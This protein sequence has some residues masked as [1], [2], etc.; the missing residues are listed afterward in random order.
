M[1][2]S[3]SILSVLS[4][5]IDGTTELS[6]DD[7]TL[8]PGGLTRT[9]V[10]GNGKVLGAR[11]E[12]MESTLEF[13]VAIT[14]AFS[15][16]DFRNMTSSQVQCQADTGQI[17]TINGAWCASPPTINQK[18]GTAKIKLQGPAAEEVLQP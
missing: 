5:V 14:G 3:Q 11:S 12:A 10:K 1:A 16:D 9:V 6:L 17:W 15:I 8:D 7:G 4:I 2:A 13:S 18:E